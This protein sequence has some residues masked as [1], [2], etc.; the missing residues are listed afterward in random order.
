MNLVI[1]MQCSQNV[2]GHVKIVTQ[3]LTRTKSSQNIFY[4]PG[5]RLLQAD[6]KIIL[7]YLCPHLK[8]Q[9][10]KGMMPWDILILRLFD[11]K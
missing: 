2:N 4:L 10:C 8:E 6:I 5:K 3:Q 11:T 1:G 9:D 7:N